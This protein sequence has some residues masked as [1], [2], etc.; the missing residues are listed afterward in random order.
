[1]GLGLTRAMGRLRFTQGLGLRI[2][3]HGTLPA[4]RVEPVEGC[5]EG[6]AANVGAEALDVTVAG[7]SLEGG[8]D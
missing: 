3:A 6:V 1:M 4:L 2:G 7:Q 8:R 5:Q